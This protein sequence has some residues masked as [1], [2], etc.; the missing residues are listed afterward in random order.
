MTTLHRPSPLRFWVMLLALAAGVALVPVMARAEGGL[1]VSGGQAGGSGASATLQFRVVTPP[2]MR[3]LE[4]SHPSQLQASA[5]GALVGQQR[6][7]VV[8][9]M[10]HGFCVALRRNQPQ[11][12]EWQLQTAEASG[13]LLTPT[14]EGYRL[15]ASRPGRY[16][17]LLQHSFKPAISA[18]TTQAT[19]NANTT[20]T[21]MAWP[22]QTDITAL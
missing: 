13:T 14:A 4:N 21:A 18:T 16:S 15:C 22:V 17:L 10:K 19:A 9:N 5:D 6:L 20:V 1:S 3:G 7:V 11:A 12:G 2:V 8:S